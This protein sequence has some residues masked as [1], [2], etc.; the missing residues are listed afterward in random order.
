MEALRNASK[1]NTI[2]EKQH[3]LLNNKAPKNTIMKLITY[4]INPAGFVYNQ[5]IYLCPLITYAWTSSTQV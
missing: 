4:K 5:K 2:P 3:G 1:C